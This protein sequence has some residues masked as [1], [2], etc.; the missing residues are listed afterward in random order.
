[1]ETTKSNSKSKSISD[2][3]TLKKGT[4]KKEL[5]KKHHLSKER[6]KKKHKVR[7]FKGWLFRRVL[8]DAIKYTKKRI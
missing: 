5:K 8:R 2:K 1:M 6:T 3:K 7:K 4:E